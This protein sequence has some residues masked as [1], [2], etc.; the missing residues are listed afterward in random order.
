LN[1][2]EMNTMPRMLYG[3]VAI[4]IVIEWRL[5]VRIIDA[6]EPK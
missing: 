1:V 3:F 5:A 4:V 6:C 2:P